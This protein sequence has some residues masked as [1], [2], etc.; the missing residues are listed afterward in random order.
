LVVAALVTVP[1]VVPG[2]GIA[3]GAPTLKFSPPGQIQLVTVNA[4]QMMKL[5]SDPKARLHHLVHSLATR[6][7][8]FDGGI[9][10]GVFSPDVIVTQ[11]M[12]AS[13]LK[14]FAKLLN[15]RFGHAY[16]VVGLTD[17]AAEFLIDTQTITT[18]GAVI[19]SPDSC[20]GALGGKRLS[21]RFYDIGQFTEKAT[22]TNF[23]VAGT[24]LSHQY[25]KTSQ[26]LCYER[27]ILQLRTE[28]E[29]LSPPMFVAGDFNRRAVKEKHECD[30]NEQSPPAGWWLEMTAPATGRAYTDSVQSFDKATGASMAGEWTEKQLAPSHICD[31]T[32]GRRRSRIDYI[33][34]NGAIV[35]QAHVDRFS[36]RPRS[37]YS[38]HRFVWGRFV[39]AG[40]PTP[41][42]PTATAEAGGVIHVS[43]QPDAS[44]EQWLVYRALGDHPYKLLDKLPPGDTSLDDSATENG[45]LYRYSVAAIGTTGGQSAESAP[46][47]AVADSSGPNVTRATPYP[48]A[49]A[50][51]VDQRVDVFLSDRP[52]PNSVTAGTI[53]VTNTTTG[54]EIPGSLTQLGPRHLT[55]APVKPPLRK[56][57]TYRVV[58]SGLR[59]RLGNAG[60]RYG[61]GFRTVA[62]PKRH[63][64]RHHHK[65][66][67]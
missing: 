14:L 65:H 16:Q 5:S 51:P 57:T 46:A 10:G 28:L 34:E 62:P 8:A 36:P 30:P 50:V 67:S 19:E 2:S 26:P 39:I 32:R 41:N 22:G 44:A 9:T 27:N 7:S 59:D 47:R 52:D 53:R 20:D 18:N 58:V 6:P 38:D 37:L 55:W 3:S 29:T 48:R 4:E 60:Y 54:R 1:F 11:E 56:A 33:F 61:S 64:H 49:R 24:H 23:V 21:T 13:N 43:W 66:R 17:T 15:R 63:K 35:A 31:G 42:A 12:Q 40:P 25:N 45:E